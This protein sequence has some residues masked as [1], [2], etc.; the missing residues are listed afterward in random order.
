MTWEAESNTNLAGVS[1]I[2]TL[3]F[4]SPTPA[5]VYVRDYYIRRGTRAY[6]LYC[7]ESILLSCA[8]KR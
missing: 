3:K 8:R 5:K 4:G 2:E 6:C 1:R 7:A